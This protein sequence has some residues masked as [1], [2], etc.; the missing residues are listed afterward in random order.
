V[1][2]LTDKRVVLQRMAAVRKVVMAEIS[3]NAGCGKIAS[4]I[5]SEGYA[6]GYLQALDDI[7]D[8][9]THGHPGDH[10]GYWEKAERLAPK[11]KAVAQTD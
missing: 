9:L 1:P 10:R 11:Q 4:A 2:R 7:N 5:S 3:G 6:G 8:A